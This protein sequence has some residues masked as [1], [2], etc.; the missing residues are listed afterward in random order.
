MFRLV[1]LARLIEV[2]EYI[3]RL[4]EW[5]DLTEAVLAEHKLAYLTQLVLARKVEDG[6]LGEI[7]ARHRAKRWARRRG[8]PS[9]A[10]TLHPPTRTTTRCVSP[11]HLI[12][13][14]NVRRVSA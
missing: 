12:T 4:E 7:V 3:S 9:F 11:D 5:T 2:E 1:R 8:R 6:L 14:S 10:F 13:D